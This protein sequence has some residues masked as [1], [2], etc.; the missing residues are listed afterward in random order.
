MEGVVD[1]PVRDLLT[2]LGGIDLCVT[3]FVRVVDN[4]L[5]PKVYHR[6]CP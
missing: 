3:E 5:P 1:A 2:R 4:L 6:L